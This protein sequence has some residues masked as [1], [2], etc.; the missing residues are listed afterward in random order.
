[1]MPIVATRYG[2]QVFALTDI[3][4]DEGSSDQE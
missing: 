4:E 1:M 2:D 3:G